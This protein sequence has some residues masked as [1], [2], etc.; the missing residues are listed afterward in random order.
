[1]AMGFRDDDGTWADAAELGDA[2]LRGYVDEYDGDQEWEVITSEQ[3][4][5]YRVSRTPP[6]IWAI[7]VI[8][9]V[10]R[11]RGN[12]D[13][14]IVDHKTA[15]QVVTRHL[16]M[17]DQAGQ[18]YSFGVPWL[19]QQGIIKPDDHLACMMYNFLRKATPKEDDRPIN[20]LGERLNKDG[21]VSKNQGTQAPLFVRHKTYRDEA[22][23]ISMRKRTMDEAE[24]IRMARIGALVLLKSPS[25]D[26]CGFCSVRDICELHDINQ[27]W[28][29]MARATMKRRDGTR[30]GQL[31]DAIDYERSK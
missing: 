31:Q 15:G 28:K 21:S 7:G 2:M 25:R 1:M 3:V 27:D 10:W 29:M 17:D 23:Q 12:N 11:H 26:N 20:A 13:V 6:G 9:G 14:I 30:V 19:R 24:E 16:V 5:Q 8:D 18:Y 22:A 4:F